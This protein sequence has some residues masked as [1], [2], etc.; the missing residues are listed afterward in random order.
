MPVKSKIQLTSDNTTTFPSGTANIQ[1]SNHRAFNQDVIDTMFNN[2]I[3]YKAIV[4]PSAQI[5]TLNT[6]PV[7]LIPS[8]GVDKVI[9]PLFIYGVLRTPGVAY[10]GN[11]DLIIYYNNTS[12]QTFPIVTQSNVLM[13]TTGRGFLFPYVQPSTPNQEQIRSNQALM[14]TTLTGNP[15]TGDRDLAIAITYT[16]FDQGLF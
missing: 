14:L 11:T 1:A 6:T 8:P 13:A 7:Q 5:L 9:V 4:I 2:F 12:P 16:I 10:S 15:T 3:Q